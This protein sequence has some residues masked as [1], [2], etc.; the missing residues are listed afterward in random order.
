MDTRNLRGTA[1]ASPASRQ[2][3]GCLMEGDRVDGKVKRGSGA[4]ELSLTERK[5]TADAAKSRPYT[6]RVWFFIT[7]LRS[8][9]LYIRLRDLNID[10]SRPVRCGSEAANDR[11]HQCGDCL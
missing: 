1:S 5:S 3:I 2:E 4:M 6:V 10:P 8:H 7:S 9:K 11:C